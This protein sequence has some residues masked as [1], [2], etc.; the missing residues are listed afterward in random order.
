[1]E[2]ANTDNPTP[3]RPQRP[4]RPLLIAAAVVLA[5]LVGG[6]VFFAVRAGRAASAAQAQNEQLLIDMAQRDLEREYGQLNDEFA[7]FENQRQ[8]VLDDS[9]KRELNDK[10][11]AARVQI[12]RLQQELSDSERRSA[13]EINRLRNEIETLRNLLRHYVEQ[14]DRLNQENQALRTENQEIRQQNERLTSRVDQ[15]ARENRELSERMTLAE[16]LNV[17]G[18][19]ITPLNKKGKRERKVAKAKQ[20]EVTFTIPQ[21]HSRGRE[22]HLLPHRKPLRAASWQRRHLPLRGRAGGIYLPANH[23]V[24]R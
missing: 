21:N 18:L 10:Y 16:R 17:T 4:M 2:Q 3:R 24:C 12:E 20:L 23:R 9:V 11:E 1:M 5:L 7:T 22:N 14:I 6:L 19:N 13:S 8:L 15:T